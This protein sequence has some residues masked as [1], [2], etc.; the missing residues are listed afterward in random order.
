M[1]KRIGLSREQKSALIKLYVECTKVDTALNH[2]TTR[3]RTD[4]FYYLFHT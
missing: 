3:A 4:F 1:L 2:L